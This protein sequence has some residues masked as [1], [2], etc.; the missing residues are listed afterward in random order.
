MNIADAR[1]AVDEA[2]QNLKIA[3]AALKTA[4]EPKSIKEI[5][6]KAFN[7]SYDHAVTKFSYDGWD[8]YPSTDNDVI[9]RLMHQNTTDT[10]ITEHKNG[11]RILGYKIHGVYYTSVGLYLYLE[12]KN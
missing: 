5:I 4:E 8:A 1:R 6:E 2:Q 7:T 12:R 9:L 3:T 10:N 11:G